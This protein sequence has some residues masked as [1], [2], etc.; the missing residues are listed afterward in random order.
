MPLPPP[1]VPRNPTHRRTIS[2]QSFERDDGLWDIEGH[3]TDVW[4]TDMALH[5]GTLRAG[6]PMHSMWLRLTVDRTATVVAA[7]GATD[8]GPYGQ[9]VCGAI[10]PAYAGLVGLRIARGWR[11]AIRERF[12]RTAGCT[13]MNELANV[14]GSAAMQSMW[15][16]LERDPDRP[17]LSIDG[18]HAL[19]SDGPQVARFHPRWFRPARAD[20]TS[21]P[22][23]PKGP[24]P[25]T[26]AEGV[27]VNPSN[28]PFD[29]QTPP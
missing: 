6:A 25:S 12:G 14:M 17:P 2:V 11:N 22:G 29:D 10:T 7:V 24:H 28:P 27:R 13:H 1:D 18:C 15:S 9:A 16:V 3:L 8:A 23:R 21:P 26:L 5:E 4:P 19:R 20:A